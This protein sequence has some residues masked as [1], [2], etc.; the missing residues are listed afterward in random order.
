MTCG[1]CATSIEGALAGVAGVVEAK[2]SY[3][4]ATAHVKTKDGVD[5]AA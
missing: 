1:Q 2:V 3:D 5:S 4:E